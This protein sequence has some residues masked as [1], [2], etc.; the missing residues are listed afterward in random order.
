MSSIVKGNNTVLSA[1]NWH[2]V[3]HW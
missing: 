3:H 2:L 1:A